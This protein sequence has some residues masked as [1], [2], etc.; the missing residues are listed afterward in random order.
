[1]KKHTE[2]SLSS[3][4]ATCIFLGECCSVDT[5]VEYIFEAYPTDSNHDE[6]TDFY[7]CLFN[8]CKYIQVY[9]RQLAMFDAVEKSGDPKSENPIEPY[10]RRPHQ[11]TQPSLQ[12]EQILVFWPWNM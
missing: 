2:V 10:S 3:G 1:M 11:Q 4:I 6:L 7:S 9:D 12:E 5:K 8:K